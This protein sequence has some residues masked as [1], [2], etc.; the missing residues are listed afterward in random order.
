MIIEIVNQLL[1][2]FIT[3]LLGILLGRSNVLSKQF[4]SDL[5]EFSF[6]VLFPA[7]IV[8]AFDTAMDTAALMDGFKLIVVGFVWLAVPFVIAVL[9]VRLFK[10]KR[11]TANVIVFAM[12]F[13][14]LGFAGMG[15]VAGI[16]GSDGLYYSNMLALVYR[17]TLIPFGI[18][19]MRSGIDHTEEKQSGNRLVRFLKTPTIVPLMIM[20]PLTFMGVRLPEVVYG[21]AELLNGCLAPVGMLIT[22]MSVADFRFRELIRGKVCH[23]ISFLRLLLFPV[24]TGFLMASLG[25]TGVAFDASYLI[26]G[27]PVAANCSL[28]AQKYN[29]DTKLAAQCVLFSTMFSMVTIPVLMLVGQYLF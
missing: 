3:M 17:L 24:L 29:T 7:S 28:L 16:Y 18:V 2:L 22:G 9:A 13:G 19:I 4:R 6:Q 25:I 23:L 21:T 11:R 5:I 26:M 12:V 27:M 15:I 1:P 8:Y 20:L 14:N 10:V